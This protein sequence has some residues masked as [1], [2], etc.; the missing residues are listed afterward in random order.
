MPILQETLPVCYR[1]R[2]ETMQ[3]STPEMAEGEGDDAELAFT[4]TSRATC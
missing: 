2:K 1:G 4:P 3:A